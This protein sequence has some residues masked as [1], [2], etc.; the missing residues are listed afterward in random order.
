MPI[1]PGTDGA[2]AL[3]LGHVIVRDEL[4]DAEFVKTWTVGFEEYRAYVKDKTPTWA[5]QITTVPAETIE[6]IAK[7]LATTKPAI[8]DAW[9]GPGQHSNGVQ[10]GRA[11]AVLG[12]L[13]GGYDRKGTMVIPDKRG[14]KYFAPEP[15][16]TAAA[17]RKQPRFDELSKYPLGHS[18][19]VYTQLFENLAEGKGP[20]Q[21]KAMVVVFQN[22]MMSVPGTATVAKGLQKLETLIVVDTMLSE[23]AM[24]ADYV[25]PGTT[26]LE[27]YDLCSHWVTWPALGLRQPAVKPIFGQPAEYETIALLGRRLGLKTKQG[28]EF[29]KVGPLSKQPIDDVT[30][31]YEDYLSNELKGGAPGI[32]LE[33]LKALPGAVWVDKGGTK[34]EKFA[35]PLADDK[36]K[37][38]W[39]DGDPK[40]E[41]TLVYDRPKDQ[42]GAARLGLV[43][44]GKVVPGFATPSGKIELFAKSFV[45]KKDADGKPVDP[46]PVY[47]PRAWQPSP[48]F[49]LYLINWKEASHTH[50]RTQN[51]SFLLDI[52]PYGPLIMHP[53]T[54]EKLGLADGDDVWVESPFGKAL[55]HLKVTKRI[56]P[57]VVGLQHGFGHT[58]LGRQAKGR[59]MTDAGLRPSKSDPL[60]GMALHK[61]TQVRVYKA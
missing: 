59:G 8:V 44:G 56:H 37:T 33:E 38:A 47:T 21:P 20:Y 29:F 57:E 41:G 51:N 30:R 6:R 7:E 14:G 31:W 16:D 4:Y 40:A 2:L 18:S 26:Y 52:K 50:T 43:V 34:Y 48:E 39:Y 24:M 35:V 28:V 36:L 17:A 22:P 11:I 9:S 53:D 32:T 61:E 55:G 13:I 10:G 45:G 60:S 15:D 42:A 58:A 54:A 23:T 27:R 49:P 3:A 19:G 1:R 46:L 5:E 12:A 25:L